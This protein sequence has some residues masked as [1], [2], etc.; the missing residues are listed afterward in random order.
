MNGMES[1]TKYIPGMVYEPVANKEYAKYKSGEELFLIISSAKMNSISDSLLVAP[2]CEYKSDIIMNPYRI[3][4][5]ITRGYEQVTYIIMLDRMFRVS[6]RRLN[7]YRY[8]LLPNTMEKIKGIIIDIF[9]SEKLYT[10]TEA[11]GLAFKTMM[12]SNGIT[13]ET[14][15]EDTE[16]EYIDHPIKDMKPLTRAEEEYQFAMSQEAKYVEEEEDVLEATPMVEDKPVVEEQQES[17]RVANKD[18]YRYI[19]DNYETFLDDYQKLSTTEMM[20][21]YN[22]P[23]KRAVYDIAYNCKS[24]SKNKKIIKHR[25]KRTV[26]PNNTYAVVHNNWEQYLLDYCDMDVTELLKKYNLPDLENVYNA[27]KMCKIIAKR[28]GIDASIFNRQEHINKTHA[29]S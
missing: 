25:G 28:H 16:M 14:H 13:T 23:K 26:S 7:R 21:K 10:E 2:V 20:E 8:S 29:L 3:S 6:E 17:T 9:F 24:L 19:Y 22:I 5:N 1:I 4:Y 15:T 18:K 12:K 11:L 27:A